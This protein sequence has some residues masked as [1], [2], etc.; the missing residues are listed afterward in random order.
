MEGVKQRGV[1]DAAPASRRHP[2]RERGPLPAGPPSYVPAQLLFLPSRRRATTSARPGIRMATTWEQLGRS[3]RDSSGLSRHCTISLNFGLVATYLT[4]P[5]PG[6]P[7]ERTASSTS[8]MPT[9]DQLLGFSR[10]PGT[11]VTNAIDHPALGLE[12]ASDPAE[13]NPL[14]SPLVNSK[15][16]TSPRSRS[17]AWECPLSK[18]LKATATQW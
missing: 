10:C 1:V 18:S 8:S 11:R 4:S 12:T 3:A 14:T 5:K 2:D 13:P 7:W 17:M 9:P 16:L 15:V 6:S